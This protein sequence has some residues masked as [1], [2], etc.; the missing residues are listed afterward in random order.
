MQ[1]NKLSKGFIKQRRGP[2]WP[3]SRARWG[4]QA[5]FRFALTFFFL[6]QHK[7][8]ESFGINT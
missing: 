3:F 6:L 1:I 4:M 2:L 7:L 8:K 5:A